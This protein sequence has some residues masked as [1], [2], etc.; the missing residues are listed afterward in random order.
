[1]R[2]ASAAWPTKTAAP[3]KTSST[4]INGIKITVT[5]SN[6]AIGSSPTQPTN[7][8][9][10]ASPGCDSSRPS[11]MRV[12]TGKIKNTTSTTTSH[13]M[14]HHKLLSIEVEEDDVVAN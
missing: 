3:S 10:V 14:R 4:G 2:S 6:S 8:G 5:A 13:V 12:R 1:M 7:P 9:A 11:A